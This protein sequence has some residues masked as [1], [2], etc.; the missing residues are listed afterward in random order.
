MRRDYERFTKAEGYIIG[1]P[2][3]DMVYGAKLDKI[4][5]RYTKVQKECSRMGGTYGLYINVKSKKAQAELMKNAF[6]VCTLAEL[7]DGTYNKGVM[8]EKS[9]YEYFGQTFRGKDSVRFYQS[10]DITI[11]GVE[12]QV[13]YLHA[14]IC[15]DTTLTKLKKGVI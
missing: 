1:F 10:G 13:K 2:V 4:P 3:G 9:V 11:D 5:R 7:E 15:Y 12:I 14:R 8:F 6:P